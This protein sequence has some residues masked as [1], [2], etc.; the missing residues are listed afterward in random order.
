VQV[1]H[2]V[3]SADAGEAAEPNAGRR[4]QC[5]GGVGV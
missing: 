2:G 5:P 4:T 1:Q 3:T